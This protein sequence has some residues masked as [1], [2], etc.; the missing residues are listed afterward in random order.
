MAFKIL[1]YLQDILNVVWYRRASLR[2][3]LNL[4]VFKA[5]IYILLAFAL[6]G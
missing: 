6:V 4:N 1:V 2:I 3:F 5:P